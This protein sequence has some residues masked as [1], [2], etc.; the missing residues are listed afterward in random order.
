MERRTRVP[1]I[2]G[3]HKPFKASKL[4]P[5][6]EAAQIVLSILRH[7]HSLFWNSKA[8]KGICTFLLGSWRENN[9]SDL[10]FLI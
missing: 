1:K 6:P 2:L 8:K 7:R 3:I 9:A 10:R 4:E 5:I